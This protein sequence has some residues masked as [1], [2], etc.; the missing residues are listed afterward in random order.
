MKTETPRTDRE[1]DENAYLRKENTRLRDQLHSAR[2]MLEETT[3]E[4]MA[5]ITGLPLGVTVSALANI[6]SNA[7]REPSGQP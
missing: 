2:Y 5:E 4:K 7:A 1:I 3:P 6:L